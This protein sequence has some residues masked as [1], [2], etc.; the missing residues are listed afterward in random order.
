MKHNI[1]LLHCNQLHGTFEIDT[2]VNFRIQSRE[3]LFGTGSGADAF[4]ETS[5]Y[6]LDVMLASVLFAFLEFC[7][8]VLL[9]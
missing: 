4:S 2:R 6:Q 1:H 7:F 5:T 8:E 3:R 9:P